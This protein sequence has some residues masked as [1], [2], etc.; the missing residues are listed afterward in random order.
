MGEIQGFHTDWRGG[1]AAVRLTINAALTKRIK[2]IL[3]KQEK[4]SKLSSLPFHICPDMHRRHLGAAGGSVQ[5]T[6]ENVTFS[7]VDR[8][9]MGS[10]QQALA[11]L[12]DYL[13]SGYEIV[14]HSLEDLGHSVVGIFNGERTGR[15]IGSPVTDLAL[16]MLSRIQD[17]GTQDFITYF[18]RS[19]TGEPL[20]STTILIRGERG[21]VIGLLCINFHLS[22]SLFSMMQEWGT[23]CEPSAIVPTETF[24]VETGDLIDSVLAQAKEQVFANPCIL[25]SNRNKEIVTLLY[26]RGIFNLKNAVIRTAEQLKISKNTVY[27]HIRNIEHEKPSARKNSTG[28]R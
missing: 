25:P 10:Y 19:K 9:I 23:V 14:L 8:M 28:A 27:M 1:E 7:A 20:K 11:G 13:G 12:S 22:M 17:D 16:Q 5:M 15:R 2:I 18:N 24:A 26:E 4:C 3:A 6:Q 21:R